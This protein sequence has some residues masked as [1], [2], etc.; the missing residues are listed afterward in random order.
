METVRY[1][2][3]GIH[4]CVVD[5]G[6]GTSRKGIII[7]SKRGDYFVGPDNGIFIS[8]VN[9]LG[10]FDSAYE[11]S[12]KD[13]MNKEISPIFH[14]RD[15]FAPAA[16]YLYLGVRPEEFGKKLSQ[17]DLVPALYDEAKA[18]DGSIGCIVMSLNKFGSVHINVLK[19]E[20]LKLGIKKGDKLKVSSD[21]KEIIVQY[22]DTFGEIEKGKPLIL[23]DDYGRVE[24]AINQ[25]S[26]IEKFPI[27]AGEKIKI[28]K[29]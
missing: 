22:A 2:P 9:V 20:L 29:K 16:A 24:I 12:N 27:K 10:G 13:L 19:G 15:I 3:I 1:L 18:V 5:P 17:E 4:V 14:G 11:L 28:S 6:V 23:P 8:A 26:L 25:G 7:R 21:G